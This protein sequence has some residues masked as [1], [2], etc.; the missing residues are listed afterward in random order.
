MT[1]IK[2][3][4]LQWFMS[5]H[6][7]WQLW[8]VH[9]YMV[10]RLEIWPLLIDSL[11]TSWIWKLLKWTVQRA[12]LREGPGFTLGSVT[13]HLRF[14]V[15]ITYPPWAL[16][17]G[18][19]TPLEKGSYRGTVKQVRDRAENE[20]ITAGDQGR[21]TE[22]KT[23]QWINVTKCQGEGW[24]DRWTPSA[25]SSFNLMHVHWDYLCGGAGTWRL[26]PVETQVSVT[27][28]PLYKETDLHWHPW[29]MQLWEREREKQGRLR[30][31]S[32]VNSVF[33]RQR[34]KKIGLNFVCHLSSLRCIHSRSQVCRGW[35][36]NW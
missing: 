22:T 6:I 13:Q 27:P 31:H 1:W 14:T 34:K 20:A 29:A 25:E 17:P 3:N 4:Q 26:W 12:V 32:H 16:R 28:S 30:S 11:S 8:K 15:R 19:E 2:A 24:R 18:N 36:L 21:V 7:N 5:C 23:E 10:V 9:R 35:E 33:G